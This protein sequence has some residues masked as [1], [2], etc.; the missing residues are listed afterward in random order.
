MDLLRIRELLG[1]VGGKVPAAV[2]SDTAVSLA[3]GDDRTKLDSMGAGAIANPVATD[4]IW[5][6]AGQLVV[7]T[8]DD[9]ATALAVGT[10]GQ[11][12]SSRAGTP[13]WVPRP[14]GIWPVVT[15]YAE[16]IP[17]FNVISVNLTPPATG[18]M[19]L[20]PIRLEEGDV[21]TNIIF[22]SGNTALAG[23]THAWFALYDPA[24]ALCGQTADDTSPAWGTYALRTKALA[25]PYTVPT[26]GIY[27]L[28]ACICATTMPTLAGDGNGVNNNILSALGTN[29]AF[30]STG[31][32][33][34]TAPNPA[35]NSANWSIIPYACVS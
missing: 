5:T 31:P 2:A 3:A 1:M 24:L 17:W 18:Q 16:T 25:T 34:T 28:A 30:K 20:T 8:G 33:T 13:K 27:R 14:H 21:V 22:M 32:Y 29:P 12:L 7:G 15:G 10:E 23:G 35:V 26:S 6:A 19:S 4:E 11:V 9:T